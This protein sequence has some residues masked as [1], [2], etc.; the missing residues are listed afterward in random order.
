[1]SGTH[2]RST[3]SPE[4]TPPPLTVGIIIANIANIGSP[5]TK[6]IGGIIAREEA[7]APVFKNHVPL[8]KV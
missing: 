6:L 2:F 4:R 5:L 7:S 3:A 8:K 1:V